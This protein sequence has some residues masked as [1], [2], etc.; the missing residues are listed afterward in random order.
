MRKRYLYIFLLFYVSSLGAQTNTFKKQLDS[1]QKLRHL[2]KKNEFDLETRITY[3]K[4]AVALSKSMGIDSLVLNSNSILAW[5]YL[6]NGKYFDKTK[7]LLHKNLKDAYALHDTL[8]IYH[9]FMRLGYIYARSEKANDSAYYYYYN[10]IKYIEN[11][12]SYEEN[13]Y[14]IYQADIY[15]NIANLQKVEQ[16]YVGS[17]E[18]II[19]A[20]NLILTVPES[21]ESLEFL[22]DAYNLL[23]LN[24]KDLKEYQKAV[25]YFQKSLEISNIIPNKYQ[26]KL[27]ALINMAEVYKLMGNYKKALI[28]YYEL[29]EDGELS[30]KDP[31]SYGAILNNIAYTMFL[32]KDKNVKK[33]DSLF[34]KA[35]RIFEDLQLPYELSASSNDMSKFYEAINKKEKAL[36]YAEKAYRVSKS[37]R[38]YEEKLRALKQLSKLKKGDE[39]KAYLYEYIALTDS[40][41]TNERANRNKFA[42]IQFETDEYIKETERLSTQNILISII[43]VIFILSLGLLYF[44]RL[45]Q[46]KNQ[47]LLFDKEQQEANQEIYGLMLRQQAKLEEGR[48]QERHRISEDLH[49]GILSQLL[50]TRMN[51]GFLDLKGDNDTIE[52]YH[53]FLDEIQKIEKEIRSLSHELKGDEALTKTNFESIIDQY[54]KNQSL[55]GDFKYEIINR[56]ILFDNINDFTKVNMY[57]ILQ[58]AIQNIIKHSKANHVL[59]NFY[60]EAERLNLIIEDDGVGFDVSS[61]KKGIG[62]KNI[63][64]RV[65][66]L[67]GSF[68]IDTIPNKKTVI[69]IIIPV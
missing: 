47:R 26:N 38:R 34:N 9:T 48:M 41:I 7:T 16:D 33:I 6:H 28:I 54:L 67:K 22:S 31:S 30:K 17:Q 8:N 63:A 57:R 68:K 55:I 1:I 24:L 35:H 58:E 40:L 46:G 36:S 50:G 69:H 32:D 45:Q 66:K 43:A 56:S 10:A 44:I 61:D 14:K 19:N 39:G 49:D 20:I 27:Y 15:N 59:I 23:G 64:S 51:L 18:T 13:K 65:Q 2:S 62:L 11:S 3:A 37:T 29:L 5:V 53:R 60:L 42:R 25:D 21:Q 4:Q 52:D 12:S